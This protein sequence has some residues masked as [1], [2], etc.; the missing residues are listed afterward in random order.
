MS[1]VNTPPALRNSRSL[2]RASSAWSRAWQ[3]C[4]ICFSSSGRQVVE[5]LVHGLARVDLVLDAV[6][7]GHHHGREGQVGV[8]GGIREAH[9]DAPALGVGITNGDADGGGTVAGE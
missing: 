3:T 4:G 6:Q 1:S 7:A 8:G 9:L 5:V 2:S